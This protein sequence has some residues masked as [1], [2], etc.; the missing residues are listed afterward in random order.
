MR[1]AWRVTSALALLLSAAS[2]YLSA[3]L[4]REVQGSRIELCQEGNVRHDRA[5]EKLD[6]L[7]AELPPGSRRRRAERSRAR[8]V[9]LIEALVP[10][11]N[12]EEAV[13]P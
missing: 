2:I 12:C 11:R 10:K 4:F 8:T 3:A 7:I 5:I 13:E 9:A 1:R 6:E